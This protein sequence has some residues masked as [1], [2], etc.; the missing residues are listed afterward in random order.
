MASGTRDAGERWREAAFRVW[1]LIGVLILVVAVS[2]V[3]LRIA[4]ALVPFALA[5]VIVYLF[6][7]PVDALERRGMKRGLAIAACYLASLAILVLAGLFVIPP[8]IEQVREFLQSFPMYY[9]R[10]I[11]TWE[12]FSRRY[13]AMEL[14]PWVDT[15]LASLREGLAAGLMSW[16]TSLAQHL[17]SWGSSAV[18]L[19]LNG[20]LAIVASFWLLKDLDA[21]K[22]EVRLLAGP[23]RREEAAI[24]SGTVSRVLSGYLRGQAI[25]SAAT[26]VIVTLGFSILGVPYALVLGLLAG[27]LNIIPWFGPLVA[28][29]ISAIVAV[30]VSP[31]L[32]LGAV[33]V[34]VA[35]QQITDLLI[36][37]RVMSEQVDLH[38]VLVI[39]SLLVGA[40]LAGFVGMVIAIPVAA[41]AKGVFVYYFEKWTDSK[42]TTERG[43]LFKERP[44][45]ATPDVEDAP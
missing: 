21:I 37:P 28:E 6:R 25:V 27:A 5:L 42:I 17:L 20:F 41:I 2:F 3:L 10:A 24:I 19:L 44:C 1:T 13:A 18:S 30:F 45:D 16:S 33:L 31:W 26:A 15:A 4:R 29:V 36:T 43:A 14:P 11:A 38:P 8:L 40:T 22:R 35:A 32:A 23:K 39:F 7:G 34:I 9:D 12:D